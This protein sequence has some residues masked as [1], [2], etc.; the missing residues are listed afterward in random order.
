MEFDFPMMPN[1][2]VERR[3][4]RRMSLALYPSRVR[5]TELLDVTLLP[6]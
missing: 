5:S 3:A 4:R 2:W 6:E 1:G